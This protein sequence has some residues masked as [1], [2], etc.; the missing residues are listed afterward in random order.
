MNKME[1]VK[2]DQQRWNEIVEIVR[3]FLKRIGYNR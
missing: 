2:F 3:P 1:M